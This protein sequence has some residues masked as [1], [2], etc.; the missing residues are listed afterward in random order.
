MVSPSPLAFL[1]DAPRRPDDVLHAG[2]CQRQSKTGLAA[3]V[4][5][6]HRQENW[7]LASSG[8]FRRR[9][10][11]PSSLILTTPIRASSAPP[12]LRPNRR[13]IGEMMPRLSWRILGSSC[14]VSP[15]QPRYRLGRRAERPVR[16]GTSFSPVKE[17]TVDGICGYAHARTG[18]FAT[19]PGAARRTFWDARSGTPG[20]RRSARRA[21]RSVWL[22][23]C[24]PH[25]GQV[26]ARRP[27]S[28]SERSGRR[29][30]SW[31]AAQHCDTRRHNPQGEQQEP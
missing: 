6:V 9:R 2:E 27:N 8:Q 21:V 24:P 3:F 1:C 4:R 30:G 19:R 23:D 31:G 22:A 16:T 5:P 20:L 26:Q 17:G 10:Y 18:T 14:A 28:G 25:R 12:P 13:S 11:D 7:E 29:I 15:R